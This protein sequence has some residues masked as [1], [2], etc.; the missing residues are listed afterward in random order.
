M[1]ECWT[2]LRKLAQT[3]FYGAREMIKAVAAILRSLNQRP[4]EYEINQGPEA[5]TKYRK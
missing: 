1:K 3:S 5:Y 2:Y 4:G